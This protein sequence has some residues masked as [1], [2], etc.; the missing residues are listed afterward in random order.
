MREDWTASSNGSARF[1]NA[2]IA[3]AALRIAFGINMAMHGVNRF[4]M[5]VGQFAAKMGQEFSATV[6]PPWMVLAFGHVLPFIEFAIGILLLIGLWTRWTLLLGMAVMAMLMF[7]TALKGDW[8]ILG[9]Q[10]LYALVYYLLLARHA[11]DA[12]GVDTTR[13]HRR[14]ERGS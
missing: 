7:G 14:P 9:T 1:R 6:L 3:Y 5:G 10:L 8:N 4:L 12:L 13:R 2:S 11:D